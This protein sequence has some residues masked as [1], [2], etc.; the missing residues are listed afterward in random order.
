MELRSGIKL[1][2]LSEFCEVATKAWRNALWTRYET[3]QYLR[4]STDLQQYSLHNQADAI[5]RY[6]G[7]T[8]FRIV[9]T[10][11]DAARSGLLLK[12]RA[13][14]KQLL[15]DVADGQFEFHAV[16]VYDVSRWGRFQD[17]DEAAHYEYLCKSAGA[18][19]YYCAELFGNS[20]NLADFI[21]KALKRMM[22]GEYSRELGE[23][24]W[25][26]LFN[27]A[28]R[29]YRVGGPPGYGFR[30]Q[31]IDISDVLEE[32]AGV[33]GTGG[34]G[35]RLRVAAGHSPPCRTSDRCEISCG[36]ICLG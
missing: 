1:R 7:L 17:M 31:L 8:G 33:R 4:M 21:L 23:K 16:L 18:P 3:S 13:G 26:G 2:R 19:V 30:R 20:N 27:L 15:E 28:S 22:A 25:Q 34:Y 24:V 12:N 32:L 6:A 9:K 29:G 5:A 36:N 14:L 10:Y 11:S 35:I